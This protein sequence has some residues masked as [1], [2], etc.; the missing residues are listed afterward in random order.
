MRS[1]P[2]IVFL[3]SD[4]TT[5]LAMPADRF[6]RTQPQCTGDE[7]DV[8]ASTAPSPSL[9]RAFVLIESL[10]CKNLTRKPWALLACLTWTLPDSIGLSSSAGCAF[11]LLPGNFWCHMSLATTTISHYL[12]QSGISDCA[13]EACKRCRHSN[14]RSLLRVSEGWIGWHMCMKGAFLLTGDAPNTM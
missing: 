14:G 4:G 2:L 13:E 3:A 12:D 8:A 5:D 6:N 9:W 7:F 1:S 11:V 10:T